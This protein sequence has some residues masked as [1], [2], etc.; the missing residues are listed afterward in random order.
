MEEMPS[1]IQTQKS[2]GPHWAKILVPLVVI[3]VLVVGYGF[4]AKA[5]HLWPHNVVRSPSPTESIETAFESTPSQDTLTVEGGQNVYTN[6]TYHYEFRFPLSWK[7][8]SYDDRE[9][10]I[11]PNEVI[12]QEAYHTI[13]LPAGSFI[14]RYQEQFSSIIGYESFPTTSIGTDTIMVKYFKTVYGANSGYPGKDNTT[15]TIYYVPFPTGAK[16]NGYEGVTI[17]IVYNNAA[18]KTTKDS[19]AKILSTF[20]FTN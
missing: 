13:D 1:T 6:S 17:Q 9:I 16:A 19:Y 8:A 14:V 15:D 3:I 18:S 7:F 12:S 11:D 4:I 10:A 5:Y 20:K 2:P